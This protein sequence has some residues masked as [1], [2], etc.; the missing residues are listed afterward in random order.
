MQRA[1]FQSSLSLVLMGLLP[2]LACGG[3]DGGNEEVGETST[4]TDTMSESSSTDAE[5]SSSTD[6]SSS[7][8]DATDVTDTTEST[9]ESTTD[10][11]D[12]TE[13]TTDA[14]DT[15]ES[16]TDATE[17]GEPDVCGDGMITGSEVC[18]DG[19]NDGSYG[20]C[21]P[22]CAGLAAYCGDAMVNGPETCDDGANPELDDGCFDDCTVPASCLDILEYDPMV[23][24]GEYVIAPA[25]GQDAP[26][27]VWCDMTNDGGGWTLAMRF[28]PAMSEFNFYSMH[29]T[30]Q[31]LV[32]EAVIDPMDA[33]D[34]KFAVYDVIPGDA[35]R[36]CLRNPMDMSY[37]CKAYD[38]PATTT[39]LD[40]F[41][42]VEVGSDITMKG[43]YFNEMQPEMLE[44]LAIQGR[45]LAEASIPNVAYVRVGINIDDDQS[46]YDARVR[47]G[48]VLN[49]EAT[50]STLNDAAG[51]G[52]QSYFTSGCDLGPGVD[53]GWRTGAG[54]AA[55]PNV[56]STAGHIWIR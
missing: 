48:L 40:L 55:G 8:D 19:T 34:G 43:L 49:N 17:T 2:L 16:T 7:T 9:T 53:S 20:G 42:S 45:T 21:N 29:W 39:L 26:F 31:S 28:A 1:A 12:T 38:L 56:Y 35:I 24:D 30:N 41:T 23:G 5:E 33:S 3:D 13:S 50:I 11:T 44:W 15:T 18:D 14:T 47:F 25:G 6:A 27:P 46:C 36:G 51:F 52:A 10:A 54:F 22:D 37:G 4:A 32:N